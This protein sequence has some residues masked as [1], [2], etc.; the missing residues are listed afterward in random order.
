MSIIELLNWTFND[1]KKAI[2]SYVS[3]LEVCSERN[4]RKSFSGP[5]AWILWNPL[6]DEDFCM[7]SNDSFLSVRAVHFLSLKKSVNV[8]NY[9]GNIFPGNMIPV[10]QSVQA[11]KS[12][13][14][15]FN[16]QNGAWTG[17]RLHYQHCDQDPIAR[18]SP[19][20]G[21]GGSWIGLRTDLILIGLK[22]CSQLMRRRNLLQGSSQQK[23]RSL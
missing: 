3:P 13:I 8:A 14:T 10:K 17:H 12:I 16:V 20:Q 18:L 15:Q 5:G 21:V 1:W 23:L 11:E 7:G 19:N 4:L 6:K 2:W 9:E 22:I